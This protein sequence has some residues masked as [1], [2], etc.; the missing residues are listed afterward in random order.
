MVALVDDEDYEKYS[1]QAWYLITGGKNKYAMRSFY[2][3]KVIKRFMHREI[4]GIAD[5]KI[6]IDH[7][8]GNGLNNQKSN[9]RLCNQSQNTAN[10]KKTAPATSRYKGV[11]HD[12]PKQGKRAWCARIAPNGKAIHIGRFSTEVE[13]AL[14]Y[15]FMAVHHYG[16]FARLNDV[17]L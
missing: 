3:K 4:L 15:N 2:V 10:M 7:I 9:L 6:S 8:D 11:F 16:E 12:R 1:D 17:H 14:A 5:P 13:A